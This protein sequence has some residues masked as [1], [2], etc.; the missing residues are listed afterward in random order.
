MMMTSSVGSTTCPPLS[1][2]WRGP[3]RTSRKTTSEAVRSV[4]RRWRHHTYKTPPTSTHPLPYSLLPS[5]HTDLLARAPPSTKRHLQ[6]SLSCMDPPRPTAPISSNRFSRSVPFN[7]PSTK[8]QLPSSLSCMAPSQ[9]TAPIFSIRFRTLAPSSFPPTKL[10]RLR[11]HSSRPR[12][13]QPSPTSS[14]TT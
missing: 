2:Q 4:S 14:V 11:R 8:H 9:L 3:V 1:Q 5:A 7:L 12:Q 6:T 13:Y 10:L